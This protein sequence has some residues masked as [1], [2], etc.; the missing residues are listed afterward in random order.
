[1]ELLVNCNTSSL[2]EYNQPLDKVKVEHLYNRVD[3]GASQAELQA[4]AGRN[5][6]AL[7]DEILNQAL[8]QPPTP[9]PSWANWDNSD[10]S[11][12]AMERNQLRNEQRLDFQITIAR[13]FMNNGL[14]ERLTLFWHNHFV[15]EY[16]VYQCPSYLYHYINCLERNA[17]GNFKTFVHEMGL[18][19]AMLR[20]LDGLF[21]RKNAPNENYARELFELFTL[22]ESNGYTEEDIVETAR[23]LTGYTERVNGGCSNII[24]NPNQH[25]TTEK[26]IF[27]RTGA[28]GYDDVID[29]LF[30]EKGNLI[31]GFICAK[32]Y[33]YFV[34]PDK[35]EGV[36]PQIISGLA[37]T[38]VQNNFELFPVLEQ[39]FKSE[40]FF[41]DNCVG[42]II[43]SPLDA[44][45]GLHKQLGIVPDDTQVRRIIN[46]AR[47][48][49]QNL[50]SPVDVAG[51]Q[52]DREWINT[53]FFSGRL[54]LGSTLLSRLRQ[55]NIED[56]RTLA[57]D[58]VGAENMNTSNPEIVVRALINHFTPKGLLTDQD[59]EN[60]MDAFK[61][62]DVP[63][64]YYSPDYIEGGLSLWSLSVSMEAPVQIYV[65][66]E[67]IISLPEFQLK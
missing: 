34:H 58:L 6:S 12:N 42:V 17:L 21:N 45:V 4:A 16:Q 65:L 54:L 19:N 40:H 47:N 28:W 32:L 38:M 30:E 35:E 62:D 61:I 10:Y 57:M 18:T 31:A 52:G 3:F 44:F 50:F 15:T 43:K 46:F 64:N 5:S 13:A 67:Y 60:A 56:F 22:G 2:A 66:M 59:F 29:I 41:D 26:T 49:G 55:Q 20:Y 63:E 24:F 14:R 11:E 39:L 8:L 7:V 36:A 51:W 33:K 27:G 25:D 53:F 9:A 48:L 23:A 1:M 37:Q